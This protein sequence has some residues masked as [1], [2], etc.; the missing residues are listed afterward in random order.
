MSVT[1]ITALAIDH[2]FSYPLLGLSGNGTGASVVDVISWSAL[3]DSL[4]GPLAIRLAAWLVLGCVVGMCLSFV[5]RNLRR[6]TAVV[7]GALGGLLAAGVFWMAVQRLGETAGH[8]LSAAILGLTMV[9]MIFRARSRTGAADG[10][11]PEAADQ[12]ASVPDPEPGHAS[13]AQSSST[14][15]P[16]PDPVPADGSASE[17]EH[18]MQVEEDEEEEEEEEEDSAPAPES[19]SAA[20]PESQPAPA[21]TISAPPPKPK[22]RPIATKKQSTLPSPKKA[23]PMKAKPASGSDWMQ[24]HT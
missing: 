14:P 16:D 7:V 13:T 9:L 6:R 4:S 2:G 1:T 20:A 23:T 21:N 12:S 22:A 10:N 3:V 19:Q 24:D 15:A 5:V 11:G 18:E 17:P 8:L